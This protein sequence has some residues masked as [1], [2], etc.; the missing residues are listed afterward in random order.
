MKSISV[1]SAFILAAG[2]VGCGGDSG[3]D[4]VV[5]QPVAPP[6]NAATPLTEPVLELSIVGQ[7]FEAACRNVELFN[8]TSLKQS[9]SFTKEGSF[10]KNEDVFLGDSCGTTPYISFESVGSYVD[11]GKS[12]PE[13]K[14]ST[15][16]F[17]VA[18]EFITVRTEQMLISFNANA[19]CGKSDWALDQKV[20]LKGLD[21]DFYQSTVGS[22]INDIYAVEDEVL[23][24]GGN[25]AF[26][27]KAGSPRPT[28]VDRDVAFR[29]PEVE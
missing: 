2:L 5:A 26:A 17:T 19:Y 24:F 8:L 6:T 7:S 16:D 18:D 13:Q 25:Y 14:T 29:V 12:T 28:D 9:I 3:S 21:C 27:S 22:T 11:G 4:D 23:Y 1:L 20:S 10:Q 15:I